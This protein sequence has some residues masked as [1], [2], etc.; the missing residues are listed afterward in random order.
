MSDI[1]YQKHQNSVFK[2]RAKSKVTIHGDLCSEGR[3]VT[4]TSWDGKRRREQC[5]VETSFVGRLWERL[6]VKADPQTLG[7]LTLCGWRKLSGTGEG[8]ELVIYSPPPSASEHRDR[9]LCGGESI[10]IWVGH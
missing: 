4:P 9:T 6:E 2:R 5:K 8:T 3:A 7:S 10:F 1:D